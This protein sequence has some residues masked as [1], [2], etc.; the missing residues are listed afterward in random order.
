MRGMLPIGSK[1][2]LQEDEMTSAESKQLSLSFFKGKSNINSIIGVMSDVF[3][4][5]G[6]RREPK[7]E[8]VTAAVEKACRKY[9][10]GITS[11][12][13]VLAFI[14]VWF[15]ISGTVK[16]DE[17]AYTEE[18]GATASV[19]FVGT[20]RAERRLLSRV[21]NVLHDQC[22]TS[23][24]P[25]FVGP[26]ATVNKKPFTKRVLVVCKDDAKHVDL[27][28]PVVAVTGSKQGTC[29]DEVDGI[30]KHKSRLYPITF[31]SDE[32]APYTAMELDEVCATLQGLDLLNGIW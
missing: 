4:V 29:V 31:H 5:I 19:P 9:D 25:V 11:C 32:A 26:Q 15:V 3:C 28:N 23:I 10:K 30:Q 7:I 17:V 2:G 13:W 12:V 14:I 27:I 1:C 8:R 24:Q 18:M 20:S 6:N 21:L 22:D 16:I